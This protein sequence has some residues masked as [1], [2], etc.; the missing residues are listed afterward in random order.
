MRKLYASCI[1]LLLVSLTSSAQTLFPYLQTPTPTSIWVTWKTASGTE[2]KVIWGITSGN[3]SNTIN[4]SHEIMTDAGYSGGYIYHSAKIADLTPDTKY[5]YKI[6][7]GSETSEEC[8]FRTPP[9][10][11]AAL[12]DGHVRIVIVG[13]NQLRNEPRYDSIMVR[14]KRKLVQK[15]GNN[16]ND[17][18]QLILMLG[19]QVD[20][21]T[22]DHYENVHMK[23][24][25]YLSGHLPIM[26]AVG[27]HET[28][29]TL[30]LEAYRKHFI[31]DDDMSYQGISSGTEH[32]YAFQLGNVL[33]IQ[34]S[35]EHTSGA[36]GTAQTNWVTS[37]LN[38]AA[39]DNAVDFILL[40]GHRPYT[41]EQYV[42]DISAWI[43]NTVVPLMANNPKCVLQI[44]AHH[45]LYHR[46]Q[47]KNAPVYNII[48]GGTAWDQY[49]GMSTEQDDQEVQKTLSQWCYQLVD[50]DINAQSMHVET[51]SVGSVLG[52]KENQLVDEFHRIFGKASPD[53]PSITNT[54]ADP[55]TLP[56]TIHSSAYST[57]T[58]EAYNSTQFQIALS[59]TFASIEKEVYRDYENFFGMAG[60]RKDST[61]NINEGVNIFDLTVAAN[62][63]VDGT[64]YV[65]VRHRDKNMN[66]S[67]WSDPASFTV[68]GSVLNPLPEISITKTRFSPNED[69]V[70][71]FTNGPANLNDWV[72]L[73]KKG[74]IP[75]PVASTSWQYVS[76]THTPNVANASGTLIVKSATVGEY[77]L[78][79]FENDGYN[80]I[81]P[82][83]ENIYIGPAPDVVTERETYD[84][85][86]TVVVNFSNGPAATGDKLCIYKIGMNPATDTPLFESTVTGTSGTVDFVINTKAYY[87]VVYKYK[88]TL[89]ISNR[90]SFSVGNQ[91][92]SVSI[93]KSAYDIGENITVHFADGP[94]IAKDWLGIYHS[95]DDPNQDPLYSYNYVA[96]AS[97]GTS[98]FTGENLPVEDGNYFVVFFTNDSYDEISNRA[99]FSVGTVTNTEYA[100]DNKNM[101]LYPNP[102]DNIAK[103][104]TK[105]PI[106]TIEILD[107]QGNALYTTNQVNGN[108]FRIQKDNIPA[109][110][111][112]I[113][114][115]AEK[116]YTLRL[117]IR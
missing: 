7:T 59:S 66:W 116:L 72:G 105:Y 12:S 81:A 1:I 6:Q 82:R 9:I 102:M 113:K 96:G 27:N 40:V 79:F 97:Q 77:F 75:G 84:L 4:G 31:L 87:F 33:F 85:G 47:L 86:E 53:K 13:D 95:G 55:V 94:G 18:V 11:G 64:H 90:F 3:L 61:L 104:R 114:V 14:I 45:H 48:S 8:H 26:T 5:F 100:D 106:E 52:W 50:F 80:E 68:T 88:G 101:S 65:R 25:R 107:M 54:F 117:V 89:E 38:A 109:G 51:Y 69:I 28:Y 103:V 30:N 58:D 67:P 56:L 111:Y 92:A 108:E 42:G 15:Y 112:V 29:G 43:K 23:K 20:V 17:A 98:V 35:T 37:V 34:T 16:F 41:A 91:I 32:Y 21:G 46:G 115:Q 49:W 60:G 19:D 83:I 10:A 62:S 39:S 22:L 36:T 99:Y 110:M 76:G 71:S 63:L 57:T 44:G 73:Y 2:S 70:V 24:T 78:T 93:D 74:D